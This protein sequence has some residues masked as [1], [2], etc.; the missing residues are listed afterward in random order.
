MLGFEQIV[1]DVGNLHLNLYDLAIGTA[2]G[3]NEH[4]FN[5]C[6]ACN[7]SYSIGKAFVMSAVGLLFDKGLLHPED[8]VVAL[9][10]DLL[11]AQM[12][13]GWNLVS[14]EQVL[15]HRV[16]FGADFLDTDTED[17]TTYPTRDYL[18]I[19]LSHP[20]DYVPGSHYQYSDAASHLL[21]RLVEHVGGKPTDQLLADQLLTP[22]GFREVAWSRCPNGHIIGATGL[23]TRASD[24]LKLGWLYLN[25]GRW[26][27]KQLLS[28]KWCRRAI[29]REYEF[30]MMTPGGLIGKGGMYGQGI[31]FSQRGGY[32]AAWHSYENAEDTGK[33]ID[34]LDGLERRGAQ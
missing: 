33:L 28:A 7:N 27:D 26:K 10:K 29:A 18:S 25:Q 12:D 9:M 24:M 19:V 4:Y 30:H 16:G 3:I 23:Y 15:T 31:V 6:N 32:A 22:M 34:Y 21:S 13:P 11:P 2:E 8:R 17:V 5:A 1:Q 14:V 20:L